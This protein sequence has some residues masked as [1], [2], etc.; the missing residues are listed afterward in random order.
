MDT[1]E[2]QPPPVSTSREPSPLFEPEGSPQ[3]QASQAPVAVM[4]PSASSTHESS[5]SFASSFITQLR[6]IE[7]W[8]TAEKS[9]WAPEYL[10]PAS[11]PTATTPQVPAKRKGTSL[12]S[13]VL[14]S[15]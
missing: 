11:D 14:G 15:Y 12:N 5:P 6:D 9:N 10:S 4:V 8:A 7:I 3:Q 2:T 1:R 13:I